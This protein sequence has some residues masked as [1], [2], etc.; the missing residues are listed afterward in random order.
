MARWR[1]GSGFAFAAHRGSRMARV[2]SQNGRRAARL[3]APDRS[4]RAVRL[5]ARDC[6]VRPC[7]KRWG[8]L[9]R[10]DS[11]GTKG[12]APLGALAAI[13]PTILRVRKPLPQEVAERT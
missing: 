5:R 13:H 12:F 1:N 11:L 2:R 7:Q 4:R 9:A 10:L 3:V 6:P 8:E